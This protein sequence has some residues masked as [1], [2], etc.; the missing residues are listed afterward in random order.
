MLH[1]CL[2]VQ[3]DALLP[4]T[5]FRL[6]YALQMLAFCARDVD[7]AALVLTLSGKWKLGDGVTQCHL[8]LKSRPNCANCLPQKVDQ[9][10]PLTTRKAKAKELT[11]AN[12]A[13]QSRQ[14]TRLSL[15]FLG[16]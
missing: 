16:N 5:L 10:I 13:C 7:S 6:S 8:R 12:T 9:G 4:R 15:R 1:Q 14:C 2:Q 11:K 3:D